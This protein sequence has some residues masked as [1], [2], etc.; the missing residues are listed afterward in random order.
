MLLE[1]TSRPDHLLET[2]PQSNKDFHLYL[3][4]P[5]LQLRIFVKL[6]GRYEAQK[7]HYLRCASYDDP[8]CHRLA[9][10]V[11]SYERSARAGCLYL[12]A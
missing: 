1:I 7:I 12:A 2:R 10:T 3:D 8:A 4:N 5:P 9:E 6:R 11:A